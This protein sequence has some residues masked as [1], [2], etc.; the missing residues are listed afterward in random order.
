MS[1]GKIGSSG[2]PQV[3]SG[4]VLDCDAN[5][6][7]SRAPPRQIEKTNRVVQ[8]AAEEI[9]DAGAK[10]K[11]EELVLPQLT[12]IKQ[13]ESVEIEMSVLAKTGLIP[14]LP[15]VGVKGTVKVTREADGS[16]TLELLA[17]VE[18]SRTAGTG[19]DDTRTEE[20]KKA[21]GNAE[22]KAKVGIT[23]AVGTK[24]HLK[25]AEGAADLIDTLVSV[26]VMVGGNV[27]IQSALER[28][29]ML[30]TKGA[31][32][33]CAKLK[34]HIEHHLVKA[35]IEVGAGIS[36]TADIQALCFKFSGN[37]EFKGKVCVEYDA[38]KGAL[39]FTQATSLALSEALE[40]GPAN[41][42]G[43]VSGELSYVVEIP[44]GNIDL[45]KLNES[46]L[47]Q[48]LNNPDLKFLQVKK[49]KSSIDGGLK[50]AAKMPGEF[51]EK[52]GG[53]VKVTE[54]YSATHTFDVKNQKNLGTKESV[55]IEFEA[56][57]SDDVDLGVAKIGFS[58]SKKMSFEGK[59]QAEA[60]SK[61]EQQAQ[62]E[63]NMYHRIRQAAVSGSFP[64]ARKG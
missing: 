58:E 45:S 47:R 54:T 44:I 55:R 4:E 42:K 64:H 60:M 37:M 17:E 24:F 25:T 43:K 57:A 61:I 28:L 11:F 15:D 53:S 23:L 40:F 8:S 21:Q 62:L 12:S 16:Y 9:R 3:N 59:T 48:Y 26:G 13:G 49:F 10:S 31:A 2:G 35:S 46:T 19:K 22:L 50:L 34:A 5:Q 41:H 52:T 6:L 63:Q 39:V 18:A 7:V 27:G 14:D 38:N 33:A 20:Q 30:D 29:N 51:G 36:L 32:N 56:K 1:E